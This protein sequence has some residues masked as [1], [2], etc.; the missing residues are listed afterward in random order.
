MSRRPLSALV[1]CLLPSALALLAVLSPPAGHAGDDPEPP[2][3]FP[4]TTDQDRTRSSNN[5]KQIGLALH[6]YH[7]ANGAFPSAAAYHDNNGKPLLSWR[8]AIL[9]YVEE[10]ALYQQFRFNEAWDSKHNKTLLAKMPK[11]F[12]PTIQGKPAKANTTYY[13]VFTGPD[14][15]F[16]PKAKFGPRIRTI[17]DGT[18]NTAMVVEAGEAVEWTKPVDL[19]YDAKKPLPKLGGLFAEGFHVVFFDGSVRQVGRKAQDAPLRAMITPAGGERFSA[20]D[21][22]AAKKK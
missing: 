5:L 11:I 3:R 2:S 19:V 8:V 6:N 10:Q 21:L 15:P 22:P 16:D 7:D 1:R 17:T 9:P 14:A 18:S 13:Q 4:R 12:A 20:E